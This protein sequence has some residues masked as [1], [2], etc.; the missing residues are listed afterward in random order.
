MPNTPESTETPF[1]RWA[2]PALV[3]VVLVQAVGL[4]MSLLKD[5]TPVGSWLFLDHLWP[6][7]ATKQFEWAGTIVAALGALLVSFA[8][9]K[10]ARWI[11]AG[12]AA[13]WCLALAAAEWKM[14]GKAFSELAIGA[15]AVRIAAPLLLATWDRKGAVEWILRVSIAFTFAIHGWESL[16]L[17][18][19][20]IDYI[21]AADRNIFGLGIRQ[22]GAEVVL[23]LIG[24]HDIAL[25]LLVLAGNKHRHVLG[26]MAFWGVVTALSRVV[27]GGEA[28]MHHAVVRVANGGLPL[29]ALLLTTRMSMTRE[30]L[31]L[32]GRLARAALP[33]I[34]FALPIGAG[35]QAIDA[36]GPGHLRIV[37]TEDPAHRATISWSTAAAGS[38]HEVHIDT[39]SRGGAV[40]SYAQ[41]VVADSNGE[42]STG[43]G[44]YHHANVTGLQPSTTYYFVVVTDGQAS[45]ERHF[46]TAPADDREFR[47]LAGGDSRKP[48]EADRKIMNGVMAGLVESDSS[49]I[50]L[51]HGGDYIQSDEEWEEWESWM[52]DHALTFTSDGRVTPI[53][54]VRGNHEGDGVM[55]NEVFGFPGG[56]EVDYFRTQLSPNV[57]LLNLDTNTSV[58]GDQATWLEGQL[59]AA[60]SGRWILTSYHEPAF[61]AAK[62]AGAAREFWV[63]LF[64]QYNIDLALESDGHVLKRT[65]P[66]RNEQHD[67][68]G[69][70]YV[71][72]GGLGVPQREPNDEWFLQSPGMATSAHHVQ[73]LSFSD[74]EM[75]YEARLMEGGVGDT[76]TFQPRRTGS[77][78]D[79]APEQPE[80][81]EQPGTNPEPTDPVTGEPAPVTPKPTTPGTGPAADAGST[82]KADGCSTAGGSAAS[83]GMFAVGGLALRKRRKHV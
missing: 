64:E 59:E 2:R 43:G 13:G 39:T 10:I 28:A 38:T 33:M 20:F 25:A 52:T 68:T 74:S 42:Y 53:I 22:S 76:Y 80:Q 23:R 37:W 36:G 18:P 15:H 21:L 60:Q 81:P 45:P 47:I 8:P 57:T 30:N 32:G 67:P 27:Q 31:R 66:I 34:L 54:P 5:P 77:V 3:I 79:P 62:S 63:P 73:V 14:G 71:G 40:G 69:V 72:E 50:A 24:A 16:R 70:V 7:L 56:A 49:I 19:D 35:A 82:A 51:A 29:I 17:H 55:Y 26:W 48:G 58:G 78:V 41:T 75:H 61:P 1:A 11:G 9:Q 12:L 83:A 6:E 4:F 46:V 44:Y 65:L